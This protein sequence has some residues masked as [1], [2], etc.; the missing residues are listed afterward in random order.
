MNE[1]VAEELSS[2]LSSLQNYE[3]FFN[4]G[5]TGELRLYLSDELY[6]GDIIEL[7]NM[8]TEQGVILTEPIRQ[9]ARIL[10]IKFKKEIAP[11]LIIV[12]AVVVVVGGLLG[13][14]IFKTTQLGVPLWVWA[15][16]G[17]AIIY[18]I[19][20]SEPAKKAGGLAIQAGKVYVAKGALKNPRKRKTKWK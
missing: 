12:G 6:Q 8:I 11:L 16:C 14:Q 5:D 9:Y 2:D 13:W 3:V 10:S 15:V 17:I 7:E 4:E 19:T 1:L 18:L 20:T